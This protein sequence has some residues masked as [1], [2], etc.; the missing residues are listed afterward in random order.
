MFVM[1]DLFLSHKVKTEDQLRWTRRFLL[2]YCFVNN[3]ILFCMYTI[4]TVEE[5][6]NKYALL[7]RWANL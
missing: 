2:N 6:W 1:F 5:V 3:N 4:V 7:Y